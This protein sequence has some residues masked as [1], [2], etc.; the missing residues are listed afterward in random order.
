VVEEAGADEEAEEVALTKTVVPRR[1]TI[2]AR[3]DTLPVIAPTKQ[4]T[5][6]KRVPLCRRR[7]LTAVVS[8]AE[9]PATFPPTAPSHRV[10]NRATT[11]ERMGTSPES[12]PSL[13]QNK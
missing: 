13:V 2:V 4:L 5:R 1:A 9:K 12:A 11:A 7:T 10:I 6:T 8:I 3:R